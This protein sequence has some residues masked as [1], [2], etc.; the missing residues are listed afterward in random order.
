[1][2]FR[3]FNNL[4]VVPKAWASLETIETYYPPSVSC[5]SEISKIVSC[6]ES[7]VA[8]QYVQLGK[9]RRVAQSN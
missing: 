3:Y 4:D 7:A 5:S 9:L 8:G 6:A 2:A 1:M